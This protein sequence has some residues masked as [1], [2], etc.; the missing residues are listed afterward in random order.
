[1]RGA[2]R[3]ADNCE[4]RGMVGESSFA[5]GFADLIFERVSD[6]LLYGQDGST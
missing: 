3:V 4:L 6:M 2:A 5:K 1:M